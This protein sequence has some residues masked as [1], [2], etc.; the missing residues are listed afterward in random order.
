MQHSNILSWA[1]T[2]I[3]RATHKTGFIVVLEHYVQSLHI[4]V[5]CNILTFFPQADSETEKATHKNKT[6]FIVVFIALNT[7]FSATF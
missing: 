6:G 5:Q 7:M 2:Q 4:H 1:H 3:E